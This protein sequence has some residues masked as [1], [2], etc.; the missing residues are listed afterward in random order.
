MCSAAPPGCRPRG[1][2]TRAR[3]TVGMVADAPPQPDV[4]LAELDTMP[5][6]GRMRR[7]ALLGRDLAGH[8]SLAPLLDALGRESP[9][10]RRLV[11]EAARAGGDDVR[12]RRLAD[13]EDERVRRAA[14]DA[15]PLDDDPSPRVLS[16]GVLE[17][18]RLLRRVAHARD[19]EARGRAERVFTAVRDALGAQAGVVLLPRCGASMLAA[20][21]DEIVVAPA[22]L[23]RFAATH[24]GFVAARIDAELDAEP[25]AEP[26]AGYRGW[27]PF[28]DA[29]TSLA[30]V[31]PLAV[32]DLVERHAGSGLPT[33]LDSSLG[34]LARAD[35]DRLTRRL[36]RPE[37]WQGRHRVPGPLRRAR[38]P[39]GEEQRGRIAGGVARGAPYLLAAWLHTMAPER[40]APTLAS[41]DG[42]GALFVPE[43]IGAQLDAL[44]PRDR[45]G[46]AQHARSVYAD[47]AGGVPVP[48]LARLPWSEARAALEPMLGRSDPDERAAAWWG[49]ATAAVLDTAARAGGAA[50]SSGVDSASGADSAD[51][52]D[53][54]DGAD[55][56][57]A[58]QR[59]DPLDEL[60]AATT[61]T[62]RE[63]D[64]VRARLVDAL[65]EAPAALWTPP[66]IDA[67][68]TIA[69]HAAAALDT[70]SQVRRDLVRIL[71]AAV[72]AGSI[73]DDESAAA[74]VHDD[75]AATESADESAAQIPSD[76]GAGSTASA[77]T[78]AL[79][80]VVALLGPPPLHDAASW[81]SSRA[82]R[83]L[84]SALEPFAI[85]EETEGRASLAVDLARALGPRAFALDAV[86]SMLA[87]AS[88]EGD[89]STARRAIPLWLADPA[90]WRERL[91][92][93]LAVDPSAFVLPSVAA[94]VGRTQ[95]GLDES[96]AHLDVPGR[97]VPAGRP[98]L[99]LR[100]VRPE[101]WLPRQWRAFADHLVEAIRETPEPTVPPRAVAVALASIP[102]VG[103][104]ALARLVAELPAP[105]TRARL[106][107]A[108]SRADDPV[109]ALQQ[110][111]AAC[112]GDDPVPVAVL[113]RC[114]RA[115]PRDVVGAALAASAPAW[116]GPVRVRR[117]AV[118]LLAAT[119]PTGWCAQLARIAR[120]ATTHPGVRIEAV[121]AL[122]G[123]LDA[124]DAADAVRELADTVTGAR[125]SAET[126]ESAGRNTTTRTREPTAPSDPM[127]S[128]ENAKTNG[129]TETSDPTET[130]VSATRVDAARGIV[131]IRAQGLAPAN[132]RVLAGIV[133]GLVERGD[134]EVR[135]AIAGHLAPWVA[136]AP[137]VARAVA[138][139]VVDPGDAHERWRSAASAL[140]SAAAAA[141]V[142]EALLAL[143]SHL[144]EAAR[145]EAGPGA[146]GA[147]GA[148]VANDV[149]GFE[150]QVGDRLRGVVRAL[151]VGRIATTAFT[152]ATRSADLV[153]SAQP[154][155]AAS[156]RLDIVR[157]DPDHD[158]GLD[159][160]VRD[161]TPL[162]LLAATIAN[163]LSSTEQHARYSS[164][165]PDTGRRARRLIDRHGATPVASLFALALLAHVFAVVDPADVELV[166]R[167]REHPDPSI[168]ELAREVH[169]APGAGS[170][171]GFSVVVGGS[172]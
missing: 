56:G 135:D 128:S 106:A 61:R 19:P 108:R 30:E 68:V 3:H 42:S 63:R 51:A 16:A 109:A 104:P 79:A 49:L 123:A 148:S 114:A 145:I 39:L 78:A 147:A 28:A 164:S 94:L 2:T 136:A 146:A 153:A 55:S 57:S 157:V 172:F 158:A 59:I 169:V 64:L 142:Q 81:A 86:Q 5:H 84:W 121:R 70:G 21:A 111:L 151:V 115:V 37:A 163:R 160:L 120:T 118:R 69:E 130:T 98:A 150:Q 99:F 159:G 44:P 124:Q 52:A 119:R 9:A 23:G 112:V 143:V 125:E 33:E 116:S 41:L 53:A 50:P 82:D 129:P 134:A 126:H 34:H 131:T 18:A 155:T 90:A 71:A 24:P 20:V 47:V 97:F 110:L 88:L 12:L 10:H 137:S 40:R 149:V 48:I 101:R 58:K 15:L 127:G 67:L 171:S 22:L 8:P 85:A 100:P 32:F 140:V 29:L 139:R 80:R 107:L 54:A 93:L 152:V 156:L 73:H 7:V 72:A 133:A 138:A 74:P 91:S 161:L 105:A 36:E 167:L 96:L 66:R 43:A 1:L 166:R 103:G 165:D 25:A 26:T 144:V 83:A 38:G 17:R 122:S 95:F 170:G 87:T 117:G 13:D 132:R 162:P 77:A 89:A 102:A 75:E 45:H 65:A 76:A 62:A 113:D 60:L 14:F 141:H 6:A 31:D 46:R 4:L 11:V 168:A 35:P 154:L 27:W 92:R